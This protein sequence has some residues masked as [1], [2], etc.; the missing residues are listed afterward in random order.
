M[1]TVLPPALSTAS[2]KIRAR[3]EQSPLA[4]K[5]EIRD[6]DIPTLEVFPE[7]WI[8]LARFLRDDFQCRYDL[9]LDLAGVDNLRRPGRKTRFEAV[10]HLHSLEN[11]DHIRV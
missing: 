8:D 9:Y 10:V 6:L 3:L 1:S 4:G 7:N 11:N 2:E 5:V